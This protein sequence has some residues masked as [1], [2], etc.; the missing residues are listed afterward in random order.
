MFLRILSLCCAVAIGLASVAHAEK[1]ALTPSSVIGGSGAWNNEPWDASSNG[2]QFNGG[3]VADG[4]TSE[5]VGSGG[6]G[7][8]W[9]GRNN[10]S[11]EYLVID[12][13]AKYRIDKID[14]YNTHNGQFNDRGTQDFSI[15]AGNEVVD[16]GSPTDFDLAP[17]ATT[18]LSGTLSDTTDQADIVPDSFTLAAPTGPTRYLRFNAINFRD[19]DVGVGLNEIEVFGTVPEP[20]T[21]VGLVGILGVSLV[22][23]RRR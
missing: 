11:G 13:G 20:G 10:L 18:I 19:G 5:P 9:L 16:N 6:S 15:D 23:R 2:G 21:I 4:V 12:L 1:I 3:N 14:L 22:G 8:P 17:G 7:T